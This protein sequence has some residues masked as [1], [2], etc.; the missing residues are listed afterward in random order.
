MLESLQDVRNPPEHPVRK[1]LKQSRFTAVLLNRSRRASSAG[2]QQRLLGVSLTV[3]A[4]MGSMLVVA[5]YRS[6]VVRVITAG[7]VSG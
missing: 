2:A 5:C 3:M 6:A 4:R 7:G 1:P